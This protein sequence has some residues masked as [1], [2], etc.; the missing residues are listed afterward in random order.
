MAGF[1]GPHLSGLLAP[2]PI[3]AGVLAVF[4]HLQEGGAAAA[5]SVRGTV[6]GSFA[7]AVFF[8]VLVALLGATGILAA[9]AAAVVAAAVAQ[10]ISLRFLRHAA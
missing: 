6:V 8:V 9:F 7:F 5:G 10:G 2:L 3:F 4:T 1:L